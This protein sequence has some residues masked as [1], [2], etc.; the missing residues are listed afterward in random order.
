FGHGPVNPRTG[1]PRLSFAP[2]PF[3]GGR[4]A[5]NAVRH[6]IMFRK[7]IRVLAGS[8]ALL[9]I[10]SIVPMTTNRASAQVAPSGPRPFQYRGPGRRPA[11]PAVGASRR[12]AVVT[13]PGVGRGGGLGGAGG[14]G[15]G[16]GGG[17]VGGSGGGGSSGGGL[18]GGGGFGG[19][20]I[21][22]G[23][24]GVGI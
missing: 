3:S 14:G 18:S 11:A 15:V 16:G 22:G 10:A 20:G 12:N 13:A 19:G 23:G 1:H 21:G 7:V 24:G 2:G 17:G 9:G 6:A 4:G 8:A 5:P